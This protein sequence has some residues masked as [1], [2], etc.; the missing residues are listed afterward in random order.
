MDYINATFETTSSLEAGLEDFSAKIESQLIDL[1]TSISN[2]IQSQSQTH[3]AATSDIK[4]AEEAIQSLQVKI[5]DI[6]AK[7]D[8]SEKMVQVICA[9]IRQLDHAKRHLQ[10]TITALKRLHML[11]NAVGQL[12]EM[13]EKKQVREVKCPSPIPIPFPLPPD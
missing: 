6:A 11:V 3:S 13:A 2:A 4:Q 10:T 9:D 12:E 5:Q 1:D 7:A 8:R